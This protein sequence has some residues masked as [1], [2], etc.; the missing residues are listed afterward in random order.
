MR[1]FLCIAVLK[2][3]DLQSNDVE[4]ESE[5][6]EASGNSPA[7]DGP[8]SR[9]RERWREAKSEMPKVSHNLFLRVKLN[10]DFNIL[11]SAYLATKH[12]QK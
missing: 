7:P 12:A 5:A 9:A 3:F 1:R 11:S 2:V 8:V 4:R 10:D 6:R